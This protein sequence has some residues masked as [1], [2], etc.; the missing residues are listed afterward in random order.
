[1]SIDKYTDK[2]N[3][4]EKYILFSLKK[5][6]ILPFATWMNLEDIRLMK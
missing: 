3:V 4:R 1:M 5:K 6:D 2:E